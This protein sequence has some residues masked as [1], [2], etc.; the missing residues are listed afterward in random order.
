MGPTQLTCPKPTNFLAVPRQNRQTGAFWTALKIS[1]T[2]GF[3]QVDAG[4]QKLV[5]KMMNTSGKELDRVEIDKK[6]TTTSIQKN[7]SVNHNIQV[8]IAA[9]KSGLKLFNMPFSG[10]IGIELY[11]SVGKI[12][13]EK[14]D[15]NPETIIPVESN[16]LEQASGGG[17]ISQQAKIWLPVNESNQPK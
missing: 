4:A 8:Q 10:K 5:F 17:V 12:L 14:K 1:S 16:V 6:P 7:E 11:D 9:D 2:L 13:F 15:I 3:T